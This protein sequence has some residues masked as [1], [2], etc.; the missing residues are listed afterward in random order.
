MCTPLRPPPPQLPEIHVIY[1]LLPW[2][3]SWSDLRALVLPLSH[4]NS[5]ISELKSSGQCKIIWN[6]SPLPS[7]VCFILERLQGPEK[8]IV[9]NTL[10]PH[11]LSHSLVP[12]C[13][14]L[15]AIRN[16]KE[17]CLFDFTGTVLIQTAT[18][19]EMRDYWSHGTFLWVLGQF[20]LGT[21]GDHFANDGHIS[22]VWMAMF[23]AAFPAPGLLP[24]YS[25]FGSHW[26]SM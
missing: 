9:P 16:Y 23:L 5:L 11:F 19:W 10:S 26:L 1:S 21:T 8:G 25:T 20:L 6:F 13:G 3:K 24:F 18:V 17:M 12:V 22:P 2:K 14:P 15:G 7:Q 4:K